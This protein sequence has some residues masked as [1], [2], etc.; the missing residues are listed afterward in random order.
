MLRGGATRA[1]KQTALPFNAKQQRTQ[2]RRAAEQERL[3][4]IPALRLSPLGLVCSQRTLNKVQC[5][6]LRGSALMLFPLGDGVGDDLMRFAKDRVQML[7]ALKALG[8][9]LVD[10]LGAGRAGG[11]PAVRRDDL[12]S[13]NRGAIAGGGS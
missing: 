4:P 13:A 2:R 1:V 3:W 12:Q 10:I 8:V 7:L 6:L 5:C 9:D 11:K